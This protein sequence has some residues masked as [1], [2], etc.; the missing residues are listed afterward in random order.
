MDINQFLNPVGENIK[1]SLEDLDKQILAKYG[2][3][4]EAKSDSEVEILPQIGHG[5]ALGA[6]CK[7]HLYEEQQEAGLRTL[8]ESPT[9][10]E[11]DIRRQQVDKRRQTEFKPILV[12][13]G[14]YSVEWH[15]T[16]IRVQ[17][18]PNHI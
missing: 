12:Y 3:D 4:I 2:S 7:L 10:A 11:I 9:L 18:R 6:L 5:E 17:I 1:D 14:L 8:L 13:D 15:C 16:R